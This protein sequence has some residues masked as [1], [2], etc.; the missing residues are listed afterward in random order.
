MLDLP[1]ETGSQCGDTCEERHE[2]DPEAHAG[3][4]HAPVPLDARP[5]A[6]TMEPVRTLDGM[7]V[8]RSGFLR[9]LSLQMLHHVGSVRL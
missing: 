5:S 7:R 8:E 1:G 9:G 6:G 4:A 3:S 2:H